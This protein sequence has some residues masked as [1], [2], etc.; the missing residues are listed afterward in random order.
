MK[1]IDRKELTGFVLTEALT[2]CGLPLEPG[3]NGR[4]MA[5]QP[6][7]MDRQRFERQYNILLGY[8][9][10]ALGRLPKPGEGVDLSRLEIPGQEGPDALAAVWFSRACQAEEPAQVVM[11]VYNGLGALPGGFEGVEDRVA[12]R[13]GS[14][15]AGRFLELVGAARQEENDL[16]ERS[17]EPVGRAFW[18]Q[19]DPEALRDLL[20]EEYR[21]CRF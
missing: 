12:R 11:A 3:E 13:L 21:A 15:G 16:G 14:E 10:V 18:A 4:A 8:A 1:C 2:C 7:G 17:P 20:R 6:E 19:A 9:A 5:G